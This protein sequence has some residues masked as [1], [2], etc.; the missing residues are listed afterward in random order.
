MYYLQTNTNINVNL[1]DL[2]ADYLEYYTSRPIENMYYMGHYQV[3]AYA[4][5]ANIISDAIDNIIYENPQKFRY[6]E[7]VE[8][9]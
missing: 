9:D 4:L 8:T 7:L 1:V 6:A 3:G 5:M 2:D